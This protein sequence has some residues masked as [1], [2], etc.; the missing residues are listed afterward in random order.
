MHVDQFDPEVLRRARLALKKILR[1]LFGG[2]ISPEELREM[3]DR[4]PVGFWEK[5]EAPEHKEVLEQFE[6]ADAEIKRAISELEEENKLV[7]EAASVIGQRGWKENTNA[8]MDRIDRLLE[9][10][11]ENRPPTRPAGPRL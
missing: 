1:A 4:D 7:S 3:H 5:F 2:E 9:E 10:M 6:D 8:A 11:E